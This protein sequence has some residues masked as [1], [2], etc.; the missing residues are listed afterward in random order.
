[1]F[2]A[3]LSRNA[4]LFSWLMM[5][6]GSGAV[7]AAGTAEGEGHGSGGSWLVAQA[8]QFSES[9]LETF[10]DARE[11]VLEIS[12]QWEDRLNNAGSQDELNNLQQAMQDEMVQAVRDEGLSVNDYNS[13]VSAAQSDENLQRRIDELAASQ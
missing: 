10:V 13:I 3:D 7:S 6:L 11:R 4:L 2:N 1:M 9:E 5:G 12:G 8:S